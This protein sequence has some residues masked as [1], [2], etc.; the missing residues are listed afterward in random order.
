M[1]KL[2]APLPLTRREM[3]KESALGFGSLALVQLLQEDL[4]STEG[5]YH[6]LKKR[7][8]HFDPKVKSVILMMQNGGPS[9]MDLFDPKPELNKR[10]GQKHTGAIEQFQPGSEQNKL[11]GMHLWRPRSQPSPPQP[12]NQV[13]WTS[14]R[15]RPTT[16]AGGSG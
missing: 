12:G 13:S 6:D 4:L 1:K 16:R 8:P 14:A 5:N 2:Q 7:E 3:L 15:D 9:Q 10:N 11:L